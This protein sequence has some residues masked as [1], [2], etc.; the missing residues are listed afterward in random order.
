METK[1]IEIEVHLNKFVPRDYQ[2]PIM[3][4]F[5]GDEFKRMVLVICRRA[6]KDLMTW[7]MLIREAINKPGV[8]FVCYPTY[9][10]GRKIL[11]NSVTNDGKRFLDYIPKQMISSMNSQELRI[12]L[13]NSSIIQIIGSDNPDC[14]DHETE[15]LTEDGWKLFKDLNKTESVATLKDGYLVYEKPIAYV[16]KPYNGEMYRGLNTSLDF[17]VTPT[18][19]FYV[20]SDKGFYK[21]K[22][23]EKLSLSGDS[24]PSTCLWNGKEQDTFAF[25]TVY[26]EW[27]TGKGR[28]CKKLYDRTLKM[29]NFVAL[30]GIFLS[31]GNTF[32]SEKTYRTTITQKKE[33]IRLKI[34]ELLDKCRLNYSNYNNNYCIEDRQLYEY[35]SQFGLQPNRFIPKD[36]KNLSVKYLKILF[37]WLVLGDGSIHKNN[38]GI[39]YYST[40]KKLVDDVQEIAIKLGYSG[41]VS[42]KNNIGDK[43]WINRDNRFIKNKNT[44]YAFS[45]RTSKFKRF[46][47]SKKRYITKE[48][49]TGM[50]YCV[51]VP[52]GVIKVRRN[53]KEMWSGNSIV[54]TNPRGIVFSEYALQNPR[55]WALLSP[56]LA[57]NGGW[58]IFQSTPRGHNGLWDLYQ[59]A[60]NSPYW[61]SCKLGLNE[62]QH[63]SQEAIDREIAEG[64][65][66][67]DMIQQEYY[68]FEGSQSVLTSSDIKPIKDIIKDDL[69]LSHAGRWRKVLKT[70]KRQY[71]GKIFVIKSFGSS[72]DIRC[73]PEHPIEIYDY[74]T[75]SYSWKQ[76]QELTT[77]DYV[78]FPKAT[79][80]K[81]EIIRKELA[82]LMA[83]YITEGSSFKNGLQLT[84][85]SQ[86]DID[87][88]S[89]LLNSLGIKF[90]L[91]PTETATNILVGSTALIDFMKI[92]CGSISYK[93]CIPFTLIAGHEKDFFFELIKGDGCVYKYKNGLER[94]SYSTI[95]KTLAYQVQLL[96][97]SLNMGLAAGIS[98]K[99]P[100]EN[101][102]QGRKVKCKESFS[103]QITY[104]SLRGQS[105]YLRRAKNCIAARVKSIESCPYSGNV[106]NLSVQYDESYTVNGRA[107]HNCSFDAGVEGSYYAK[108]ID[109][110]NLNHQIG[111]SPW[112]S[113]FPVHTAWDLGIHDSN[114]IIF[115]QLIGNT[116]R[117][118]DFYEKNK[119]G[120]EHYVQVLKS[121]PY[122]Y[123]KHVAPHDIFVNEYTSGM[124][125]IQKA[126]QLGINFIMAPKLTVRDGIEAVRS[127]L[128]RVWIDEQRC[129]KL[130]KAIENY[131]EKWD[132]KTQD[133][134]GKP[135]HS[136]Y[137]HACFTGDMKVLTA[138]GEVAIQDI[139][140]GNSVITPLGTRKVLK[141]HKRTTDKL[142]TINNNIKCTP[143]HTFFTNDGLVSADALRYSHVLEPY[144]KIRTY[145]W[146]KI[147][148]YYIKGSDSKGF[149]KTILSQKMKNKSCLMDTFIDGLHQ[150]IT[151]E[152][153]TRDIIEERVCSQ[154]SKDMSGKNITEKS[155]KDMLYITKTR[156]LKITILK[157][158]KCLLNMI[159]GICM[160]PNQILGASLKHA[161]RFLLRKINSLRYGIE[162][163]KEESGTETML[164]HHCQA[165]KEL[166][167]KKHA[168]CVQKN[169]K[170]DVHGENS[171][172]INVKQKQEFS[173]VLMMKKGIVLFVVKLLSVT[174]MFLK[175]HAVKNVQISQLDT[176]KEVYD[177][178]VEKDNCYYINGYLVSNC[179]ALRYL[180]VSVNHMQPSMTAEELKRKR[181]QAQYGNNNSMNNIYKAGF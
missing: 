102:I 169:T 181:E 161:K 165:L 151:W 79:L 85:G 7:N 65:L 47:S 99:K 93:K 56:V 1:P 77:E 100:C 24:I 54:G 167:T 53:G 74:K 175:K 73:T 113:S 109:K 116:I 14:F 123:G 51:S 17:L 96:A 58:A 92:N 15:I 95:S 144:S 142:Y 35:F 9:N 4:A 148:G 72:E 22:T 176:P 159:M 168:K 89:F 43:H 137:S 31:E 139:K 154:Q 143:D 57:A 3:Q 75:Q 48:N 179:D 11:W 130:I 172:A 21:F 87:R 78:V 128:G 156:I 55:I 120:L 106:Y 97:N 118:I 63:I 157:I 136:K 150:N 132:E 84:L 12:N 36:I 42:I 52:S 94:I 20:K 114:S 153:E 59:L 147:F 41:N 171:A 135:L 145:L 133:Y 138:N 37:D 166:N 68:C 40:S 64:N 71:D 6:G 122:L 16:E 25:P 170:Q 29:E 178:T 60:E 104:L 45:V 38:G 46:S 27:I 50:I 34:E 44:L 81:H 152:R 155:Q 115:Y 121:K 131:R 110:M 39:A 10:Q 86:K 66:S 146:R 127:I 180:A 32:K 164:K 103:I 2:R 80:G 108:Y 125:R 90:S 88:V 124:S 126:Q 119:E 33:P 149:K 26:S 8:Y 112:E 140:P 30:L 107:V 91:S 61:W 160:L 19:R 141:V 163:K 69:V 117:I 18:H 177:L 49:Y 28:V 174:N 158:L 67:P 62:T 173:L 105:K 70:F 83:W 23:V 13:M 82:L 76:A 134:T 101:I 98:V 129:A 5:F 111:L 162:A